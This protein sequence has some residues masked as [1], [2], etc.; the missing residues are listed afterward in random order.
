MAYAIAWNEAAPV[1]A[2]VNA[3]TIDTELQNLKKSVRERIEQ[4]IPSWDTD[5]TDPKIIDH[6]KRC[7]V[8]NSG[9]ISVTAGNTVALTWDT[10]EFDQG[11]LHST[12]SNTDRITIITDGTYL[13][14][15]NIIVS[16]DATAGRLEIR[17]NKNGVVVGRAQHDG[18]GNDIMTLSI[19][20]IL[21]GL[22][23]T[24]YV[25]LTLVAFGSEGG[26]NTITGVDG[27]YFACGFM[28]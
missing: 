6:V 26:G 18:I 14:I 5:G 8:Y 2:S 28:G 22:V 12:S 16:K 27:A 7:H 11:T 21:T 25:A 3:S 13:F 9:G 10:E 4:V 19:V 23:A 17:M 20:R 1:G 15:A 24:D